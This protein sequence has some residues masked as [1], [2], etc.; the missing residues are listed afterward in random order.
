MDIISQVTEL[1]MGIAAGWC[2][3][4]ADIE[5]SDTPRWIGI[6]LCGFSDSFAIGNP[7]YPLFD[8]RNV[9]QKC[10]NWVTCYKPGE[11]KNSLMNDYDVRAELGTEDHGKSNSW[12]G[13]WTWK[14]CR[15]WRAY[16][17]AKDYFNEGTHPYKDNLDT[18]KMMLDDKDLQ[19]LIMQGE[20]DFQ[21][22]YIGT[23]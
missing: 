17:Q 2:R 18:F 10:S 15:V 8:I 4:T 9:K 16:G 19:V 7:I 5:N 11:L 3:D 14:D 20:L 22:N 6:L 21:V 1:F 13:D 23:E 12:Y